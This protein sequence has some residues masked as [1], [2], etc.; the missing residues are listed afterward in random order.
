MDAFELKHKRVI[1]CSWETGHY[2]CFTTLE[3]G[4]VAHNSKSGISESKVDVCMSKVVF[5][6]NI[7]CMNWK[8]E[9]IMFTVFFY[10]DTGTFKQI[11][12]F[13]RQPKHT[14]LFSCGSFVVSP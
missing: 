13:T 12:S 14:L 4:H 8:E 3:N 5:A 1:E 11:A 2:S 6:T 7:L 10:T 9:G